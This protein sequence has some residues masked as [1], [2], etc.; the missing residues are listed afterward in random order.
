[1][2]F[3]VLGFWRVAIRV[4]PQALDLRF[5]LNISRIFSVVKLAAFRVR[6]KWTNRV[7]GGLRVPPRFANARF[8]TEAPKDSK[9]P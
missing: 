8:N 9:A 7:L 1:M 6:P 2:G 5:G 4:M 3:K